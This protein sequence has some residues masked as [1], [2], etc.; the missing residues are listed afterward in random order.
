MVKIYPHYFRRLRY[1]LFLVMTLLL[2]GCGTRRQFVGKWHKMSGGLCDAVYPATV[3]F[4]DD[5]GYVGAL[6]NW[7]GG[8]YCVVD[9]QRLRIDTSMG[10][11]VYEFK[12]SDNVLTFK[13][14]WG[15]TFK[16]AKVH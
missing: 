3:E 16:Y 8:S 2:I 4:F 5:G 7:S 9:E 10:S 11:G 15:C 13:N 12:L 6:P 14:D 1:G